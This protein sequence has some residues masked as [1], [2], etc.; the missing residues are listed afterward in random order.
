MSEKIASLRIPT[1]SEY[2]AA[3]QIASDHEDYRDQADAIGMEEAI[4]RMHALPDL[5]RLFLNVWYHIKES[6]YFRESMKA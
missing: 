5:S 1:A 3:Y 2:E 4:D 6:V